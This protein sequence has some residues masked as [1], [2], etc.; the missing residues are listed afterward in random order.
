MKRYFDHLHTLD[1][2]KAEYKRLVKVHHPDVGGDTA[3]MQDING[4]Y[5][6]RVEWIKRH[7][8]REEDR[9]NAANEV[10]AEYAAAVAAAVI[11]DGVNVDL[12]GSWIWCTG[13]TYAHREALKAAGYRFANKKRAWYWRPESAACYRG[14]KKSLDELKDKYGCTHFEAAH[15]ARLSA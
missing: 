8:E 10:P 5:A 13:N 15:A 9:R 7:G 14:G 12:V 4:Q 1:A 11:L 6:D 3:T 2:I